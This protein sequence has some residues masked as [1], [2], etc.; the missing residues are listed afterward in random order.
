MPVYVKEL[1]IRE[2][3]MSLSY[4]SQ[5]FSITELLAHGN[6]LEYLNIFNINDLTLRIRP[7]T[8]PRRARL[9]ELPEALKQVSDFYLEDIGNNQK[10]NF[11]G[12]LGPFRSIS[13]VGGAI[14]GVFWR[15]IEG[16]MSSQTRQAQ[17]EDRNQNIIMPDFDTG[18][19][20]RGMVEGVNEL[21]VVLGEEG[22]NVRKKV[23]KVAGGVAGG[24]R[25]TAGGTAGGALAKD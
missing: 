16:S 2:T 3:H 10:L 11:F 1:N 15:P 23:M 18:G 13:R 6:Q 25:G 17:I 22:S 4:S 20:I 19:M 9:F 14:W 5:T 7:F 24:V 12:A 8:L 21:V